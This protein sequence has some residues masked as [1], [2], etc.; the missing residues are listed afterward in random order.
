MILGPPGA[1][2]DLDIEDASAASEGSVLDVVN[3]NVVVVVSRCCAVDNIESFVIAV[4]VGSPF[5]VADAESN[6]LAP[7][8]ALP[9]L[10]AYSFASFESSGT[11]LVTVTVSPAKSYVV[12]IVTILPDPPAPVALSDEDPRTERSSRRAESGGFDAGTFI[13][14][15]RASRRDFLLRA[16]A[17][18][19]GV[20]SC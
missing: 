11:S 18:S 2:F 5:V 7:T 13:S 19:C 16:S 8:G 1:G 3:D 10:A 9:L 14:A 17:C 4:V 12:V 15:Q 20:G 6:E